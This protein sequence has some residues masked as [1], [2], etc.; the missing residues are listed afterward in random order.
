[1]KQGFEITAETPL[2]LVDALSF[3]AGEI[4]MKNSENS[5][6]AGRVFGRAA[7]VERMLIAKTGEV[8]G[9]I[10]SWADDAQPLLEA[11]FGRSLQGEELGVLRDYT[12]TILSG[13][14]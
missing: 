1:M 8:E 14:Y 6:Y 3:H 12:P 13:V 11:I 2:A 10:T 7:D 9:V 4:V 5:L